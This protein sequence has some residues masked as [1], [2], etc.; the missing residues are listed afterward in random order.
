MTSNTTHSA[1]PTTPSQEQQDTQTARTQQLVRLQEELTRLLPLSGTSLHTLCT[2]LP[3]IP[4]ARIV[5]FFTQP[6]PSISDK[7]LYQMYG[8]VLSRFFYEPYTPSAVHPS[9]PRSPYAA[10]SGYTA[11]WS[12]KD[13]NSVMPSSFDPII[14]HPTDRNSYDPDTPT[15]PLRNP[16]AERL[17]SKRSAETLSALPDYASI[18]TQKLAPPTAVAL[19]TDLL[20]T[21]PLF[22][23]YL[24]PTPAGRLKQI[25]K[26]KG[27]TLKQA[28]EMLGV[29]HVVVWCNE[30]R[31]MNGMST[32]TVEKY[33]HLYKVHPA[34]IAYGVRGLTYDDWLATQP[35]DISNPPDT[36]K[37]NK[38]DVFKLL[39]RF[40]PQR[41]TFTHS[42]AALPRCVLGRVLE[43][44][45]LSRGFSQYAIAALCEVSLDCYIE[46]EDGTVI[47]YTEALET[48]EAFYGFPEQTFSALLDKFPSDT[49]QITSTQAHIQLHEQFSRSAGRAEKQFNDK[50]RVSA[51]SQPQEIDLFDITDLSTIDE[52]ISPIITDI[53]A[54]TV[55]NTHKGEPTV[56]DIS[57][58]QSETPSTPDLEDPDVLDDLDMSFIG[59][60]DIFDTD[61]DTDS[62]FSDKLLDEILSQYRS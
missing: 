2:L 26:G 41:L 34:L 60:L 29:N 7:L 40:L 28:A 37:Q 39:N 25:R 8:I 52:P 31:D 36:P 51:L 50:V 46:I 18:K 61:T 48:L 20:N 33:A 55:P 43:E 12:V 49:P 27:L 11:P 30:N 47:P 9:A 4:N 53:A 42:S 22:E 10:L 44:L 15:T 14:N 38:V 59:S 13:P 5:S 24:A 57:D 45:R 23:P 21:T 62:M 6:K 16:R 1:K 54:T 58:T 17:N 32:A 35:P 19:T 56:S 3:Y